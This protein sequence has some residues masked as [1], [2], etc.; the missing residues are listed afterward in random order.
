MWLYDAGITN[1]CYNLENP[2]LPLE[3][4]SINNQFKIYRPTYFYVR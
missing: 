1:Y 2:S 4:N 3:G